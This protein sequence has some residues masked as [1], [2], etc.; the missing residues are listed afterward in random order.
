MV[1]PFQRTKDALQRK[2]AE[3]KQAREKLAHDA[4]FLEAQLREGEK[5][6]RHRLR[7]QVGQLADDAGLLVYDLGCLE[8]AFGRLAETLQKETTDAQ[9]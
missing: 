1:P 7:A 2:L 9:S 5:A 3:N 6:A 8:K 4:A